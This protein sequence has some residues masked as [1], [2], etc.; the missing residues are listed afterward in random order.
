[1]CHDLISTCNVE[2]C[3]ITVSLYTHPKLHDD[4]PKQSP[5][6][7][8]HFSGFHVVFRGYTYYIYIYY[9]WESILNVKF[10]ES[11]CMQQVASFHSKLIHGS[12]SIPIPTNQSLPH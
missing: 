3:I 1:M 5:G 10:V 11:G 6:L 4:F 9:K 8:V 12:I 2:R 7:C